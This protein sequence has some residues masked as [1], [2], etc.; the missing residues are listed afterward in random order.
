MYVRLLLHISDIVITTSIR[1]K[2]HCMVLQEIRFSHSRRLNFFRDSFSKSQISLQGYESFALEEN[3]PF[4]KATFQTP[5]PL[6]R[7][8][9]KKITAENCRYY[10]SF[11][12]FFSHTFGQ[13]AVRREAQLFVTTQK[14]KKIF[15][16][17][18]VSLFCFVRLFVSLFFVLFS[19][20][21]C[22]SIRGSKDC[23]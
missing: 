6:S 19:F 21:C 15:R 12:S 17:L 22:L 23:S 2:R 13:V 11:F 14:E 8:Q 5:L 20:F 1:Y 7:S 4:L 16:F 10:I 3:L 18:F 9:K